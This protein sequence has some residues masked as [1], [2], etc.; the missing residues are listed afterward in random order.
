MY[1]IKEKIAITPTITTTRIISFVM[2]AFLF[3]GTMLY[4]YSSSTVLLLLM[5]VGLV[6]LVVVFVFPP[7]VLLLLSFVGGGELS[8]L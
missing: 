8:M 1:P 2:L 6:V 3:F 7:L 4:C 5:N